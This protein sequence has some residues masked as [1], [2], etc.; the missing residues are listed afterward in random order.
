MTRSI[1]DTDDDG[2]EENLATIADPI[3][4]L[5]GPPEVPVSALRSS[6]PA[7]NYNV[8]Q[9]KFNESNTI[10][11]AGKKSREI[12]IENGSEELGCA[13]V[14]FDAN[15]ST[16][17]IDSFVDVHCPRRDDNTD[18]IRDHC[19]EEQRRERKGGTS[20]D[21]SATAAARTSSACEKGSLKRDPPDN[22]GP[23]APCGNDGKKRRSNHGRLGNPRMNRAVQARIDDPKLPLL[24]ALIMGGFDFGNLENVKGAQLS[25]MKDQEGVS[26]YQRR[27]QLLRRLRSMKL[28]GEVYPGGKAYTPK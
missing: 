8:D 19:R 23:G 5:K 4:T 12:S 15:G 17:E 24:D 20:L 18:N 27:N 25:A 28:K 1:F 16:S 13:E 26:V 10:D 9:L 21:N 11:T 22:G 6:S 3:D 14:A 7:F 2:V